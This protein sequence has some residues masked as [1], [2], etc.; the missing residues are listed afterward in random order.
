MVYMLR[1]GEG[2]PARAAGPGCSPTALSRA[3]SRV[4]H[5]GHRHQ[6]RACRR[7]VAIPGVRRCALSVWRRSRAGGKPTARGLPLL[8]RGLLGLWFWVLFFFVLGSTFSGLVIGDVS[9]HAP[10]AVAAGA[11]PPIRRRHGLR[12]VRANSASVRSTAWTWQERRR[13]RTL[14]VPAAH[15]AHVCALC[16][17]ASVRHAPCGVHLPGQRARPDRDYHVERVLGGLLRLF[18]N[19]RAGNAALSAASACLHYVS[20]WGPSVS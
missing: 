19:G 13:T 11:A 16:A 10:C 14:L 17:D 20:S 4:T 5:D 9:T 7:P 12:A 2:A 8:A 18:V 3:R 15:S 1:M 6:D